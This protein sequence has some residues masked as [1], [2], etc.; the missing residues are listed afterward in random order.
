MPFEI[1]VSDAEDGQNIPAEKVRTRWLYRQQAG[2]AAEVPQIGFE[3]GAALMRKSDCLTCHQLATPSIGPNFL[4]IA[5]RYRGDATAPARLIEKV[6]KGGNTWGEV[7]MP[8]H[9][10]HTSEQIA[11]MVRYILEVKP[12]DQ[13]E[14]IVGLKGLLKPAE[15]T[16]MWWGK[17]T[18]GTYLLT[19]SY[20]DAGPKAHRRSPPSPASCCM[21]ATAAPRSTMKRIKSPC[22]KSPPCCAHAASAP[23][24][25]S[26]AILFSKM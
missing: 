25:P 11:E 10:Q 15:P 4:A 24:S 23:N 18:G 12:P 26:A 7:P 13:G 16:K 3:G 2:N 17:G 5:E 21:I 19:A 14:A 20:R 6:L 1:S 22:S 8:A 9:P